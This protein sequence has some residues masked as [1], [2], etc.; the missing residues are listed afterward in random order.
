MKYFQPELVPLKRDRDLD[1]R[2]VQERIAENLKIL[3]LV[4]L[5][6]RDKQGPQPRVVRPVYLFRT[7]SH[8]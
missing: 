8:P 5:D 3:S 6:L 1:E 4:D 7:P 2:C